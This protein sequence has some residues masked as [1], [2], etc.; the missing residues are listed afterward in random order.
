[1]SKTVVVRNVSNRVFLE[2][3]ARPG[4]IGLSGGT[5]LVDRAIRRA[6]RH[7]CDGRWSRWSHAF[8]FGERRSDGHIWVIESDLQAAPKHL[9]F[10]VQENRLTKYDDEEMYG[11]LA[12]LDFHLTEEQTRRLLGH[13]LDLTADAVRYSVRELFGTLLALRHQKLR[14]GENVLSRDKSLYCSAFVEQLYAKIGIR[15]CPG[16]NLKHTVPED[17]FQTAAPHDAW[18]LERRLG[19]SRLKELART[20]RQRVRKHIR[21]AG[22]MMPPAGIA[23]GT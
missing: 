20:A 21:K 10:G 11:V 18:I 1:M 7:V 19:E 2:R 9:R 4:C 22:A 6:E 14:G 12:V 8:L 3:H 13:A 17:I 23:P 5:T 15:L 16:V